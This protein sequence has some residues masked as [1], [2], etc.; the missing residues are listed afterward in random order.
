MDRLVVNPEM[1]RHTQ[2]ERGHSMNRKK[3]VIL[4]SAL[5]FVLG[6]ALSGV[7]IWMRSGTEE[8]EKI[9]AMRAV[10]QFHARLSAGRF[11]EI[12]NDADPTF[13]SQNREKLTGAM[14][15]TYARYGGFERITFSQL[16]VIVGAP[17][18]IRAV[19]NST[20]A[21]G[22]A[23]EL[24]AFVD[25]EGKIRLLQYQIS[26]GTVRPATR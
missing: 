14:Q 26:P 3:V 6:M 18:Q 22:T 15:E 5:L 11:D 10:A 2:G 8:E 12:L 24:F 17:I 19:Y 13:G 23:T 4:A 21:K 7:H 9:G 16:N 1:R 25:R 20:F